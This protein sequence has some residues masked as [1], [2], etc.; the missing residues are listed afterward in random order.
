M[1]YKV[2]VTFDGS[3]YYGWQV[4]PDKETVQETITRA[5]TIINKENTD[6]HASG[7]TDTGVHA[8][9]QVFHFDSKLDLNENIW[10]KALNGNLPD[11][12]R[13]LRVEKVNDNFHARYDAISKAYHYQ[14]NTKEHD[15]FQSKYIY[16]Y[17]KNLDIKILQEIGNLFLGTHDFASFNATPLKVIE[18]QVRHID[19]FK[20]EEVDGIIVFKIKGSGFLR[21]MIRMLVAT[22]LAYHEKKISLEHVLDALNYPDKDKIQFNVPGCGLY[23]MNVDYE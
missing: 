21:H 22:S 7:R 11:D 9:G 5:V 2:T 12:I 14:L 1:R 13:V 18:N 20:I 17:N 4:Q 15:V 8:Y 19:T 3:S 16:Q 6:I 10:I 23:L